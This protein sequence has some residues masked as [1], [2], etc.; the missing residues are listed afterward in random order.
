MRPRYCISR[1]WLV[2]HQEDRN[3]RLSLY[4][5]N[6]VRKKE[7]RAGTG[8]YRS[9]SPK[10]HPCMRKVGLG[11]RRRSLMKRLPSLWVIPNI[12]YRESIWVVSDGFQQ[13]T[14][15]ND[16][17]RGQCTMRRLSLLNISPTRPIY[18]LEEINIS[19]RGEWSKKSIQQGRSQFDARSVLPVREHGKLGRTP[20]VAFFNIPC[21]EREGSLLTDKKKGW[22][23]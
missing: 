22:H 2:Y 6:M 19:S 8:H 18:A 1:V 4:Q 12:V 3:R 16:G 21:L 10:S 17:D 5:S 7:K 23:T 11:H 13:P 9:E 20:L 14:G 15:W